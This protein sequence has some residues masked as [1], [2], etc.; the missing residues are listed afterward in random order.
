MKKIE[1]NRFILRKVKQED[2]KELFNMLSDTT[3]VENLNMTIHKRIEDTREMIKDYLKEFE[4]GNQYPFVIIEK[5]TKKLLGGFLIKLDLYD[6]DC[7]EFTVYI[8]REFWNKGIYTEVLKYM[9]K[10]VFEEIKTGNFR[11][12]VM[13][14]NEASSKVLEKNNFKLEKVFNVQGLEGKIKSYLMTREEYY[15]LFNK[16]K[17]NVS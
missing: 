15:K 1:T 6:E 17:F 8:K 12:F 7:F 4:K 14:K 10:F 5:N 13:E 11:G 16:D 3:V 2:E 9:T